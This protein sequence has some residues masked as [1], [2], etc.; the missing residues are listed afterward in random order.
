MHR[1][2]VNEMIKKFALSVRK[3][4][5]ADVKSDGWVIEHTRDSEWRFGVAQTEGPKIPLVIGVYY[6]DSNNIFKLALKHQTKKTVQVFPSI[7][8][9]FLETLKSNSFDCLLRN[10]DEILIPHIYKKTELPFHASGKMSEVIVQ[11]FKEIRK[12]VKASSF[13]LSTVNDSITLQ[14]P[15]VKGA[16]WSISTHFD[17][18]REPLGYLSVNGQAIENATQVST[19]FKALKRK[20]EK[21][22]RIEQALIKCIED[23]NQKS[24]YDPHT[25]TFIV[26]G[27]RIPFAVKVNVLNGRVEESAIFVRFG[28]N[29]IIET[30]EE[31][32]IKGMSH[33]I[34]KYILSDRL[35][36]IVENR[37]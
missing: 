22:E 25:D 18:S 36:A 21:V 19:Y 17:E 27:K 16:L 13:A 29:S 33:H 34:N 11:L 4:Y 6:D 12:Q 37:F 20:I 9:Y 23:K 1:D 35:K 30:D 10:D 28:K 24:F 3:R 32:I 15:Y 2:A 31:V 14:T 26:Y 8:H 7:Y 5:C